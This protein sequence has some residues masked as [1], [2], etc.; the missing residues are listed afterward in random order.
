MNTSEI[1]NSESLANQNLP[2]KVVTQH[3]EGHMKIKYTMR[4]VHASIFTLC[5]NYCLAQPPTGGSTGPPCF[6][7]PCIPIDQGT[8]LL[9]L[10][11]LCLAGYMYYKKN[12]SELKE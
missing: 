3:R 6:P 8:I 7:P 9:G 12:L 2:V 11:G 5:F 10:A 4:L 1:L